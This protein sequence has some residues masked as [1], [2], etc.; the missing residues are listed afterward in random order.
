[1]LD[2]QRF[3]L[4]TIWMSICLI[5]LSSTDICRHCWI[6]KNKTKTYAVTLYFLTLRRRLGSIH[7]GEKIPPPTM[8]QIPNASVSVLLNFGMFYHLTLDGSALKLQEQIMLLVYQGP[9]CSSSLYSPS[10]PQTHI[11]YTRAN[12]RWRY[13]QD[14]KLE[15]FISTT[16]DTKW[17]SKRNLNTLICT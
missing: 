12:W 4:T 16:K 2:P 10:I 7:I 13:M 14:S 6:T 8:P 1:V 17:I 9:F 11:T 3:H 15:V 5:H